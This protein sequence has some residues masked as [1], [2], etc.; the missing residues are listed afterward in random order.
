[1]ARQREARVLAPKYRKSDVGSIPPGVVGCRTDP[2]LDA[3]RY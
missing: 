2:T 1:M 3:L